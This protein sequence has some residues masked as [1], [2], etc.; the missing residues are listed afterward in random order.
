MFVKV[1]E[2]KVIFHIFSCKYRI[3]T[4][5]LNEM[6]HAEIIT[7]QYLYNKWYMKRRKGKFFDRSRI[8]II[9]DKTQLM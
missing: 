7:I 8:I 1:K 6:L 9:V 4:I 2:R 3:D 5:V